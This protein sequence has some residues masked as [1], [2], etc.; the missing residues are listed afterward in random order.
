MTC[1]SLPRFPVPLSVKTQHSHGVY[2]TKSWLWP[3]VEQIRLRN[4]ISYPT[5]AWKK[6]A[7]FPLCCQAC[8]LC[9]E[10]LLLWS[11]SRALPLQLAHLDLHRLVARRGMQTQ[12]LPNVVPQLLVGR[13]LKILEE[14][15]TESEAASH[16][17]LAPQESRQSSYL[18]PS[19]V[20]TLVHDHGFA[21]L[22]VLSHIQTRSGSSVSNLVQTKTQNLSKARP[23][24]DNMCYFIDI[25]AQTKENVTHGARLFRGQVW[26]E[27]LWI[28]RV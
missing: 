27:D 18:V 17:E 7:Q 9:Q 11:H 14:R 4:L 26:N 12:L 25:W 21:S 2:P 1:W 20:V 16:R 22:V 10:P 24:S 3:R 15:I 13:V 19:H 23:R 5:V 8:H 6:R 28:D